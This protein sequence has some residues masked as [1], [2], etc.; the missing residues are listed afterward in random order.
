MRDKFI[1]MLNGTGRPE[2]EKVVGCLD[3][4][5]FF[6]APASTKHHLSVKGGLVEHSV[7][8]CEVALKLRE[9]LVAVDPS[10]EDRLPVASVVFCALLH[11]V[12][13]ADIYVE[14]QKWKKDEN[15][16]WQSYL[17]YD[18]D[19]SRC[20][21]GHGEKS[22]MRL[23][24]WGVRLTIDEMLAIRWHMAAWDLPFQS[25]ETL[26]NLNAARDKS[27]LVVLLQCADMLASGVI[28]NNNRNLG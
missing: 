14:V 9:S 20:P 8:V 12:C 19:Y 15:G 5:G 4:I 22:V 28:E 26:G 25:Y 13:K 17:A 3:R 23:Q 27:P 16:K 11:D 1:E 21:L 6:S 2:C 7:H 18:V 10:M 24:E